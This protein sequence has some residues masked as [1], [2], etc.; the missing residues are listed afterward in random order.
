MKPYRLH[1]VIFFIL[2]VYKN[3]CYIYPSI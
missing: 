1:Q 2:T 3:P